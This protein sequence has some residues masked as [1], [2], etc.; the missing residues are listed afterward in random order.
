VV[1]LPGGGPDGCPRREFVHLQVTPLLPD[2]VLFG[3]QGANQAL[4]ERLGLYAV[5]VETRMIGRPVSIGSS[6][7]GRHWT[8]LCTCTCRSRSCGK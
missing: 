6:A 5:V 8:M 1:A 4:S 7:S 3:E 2:F